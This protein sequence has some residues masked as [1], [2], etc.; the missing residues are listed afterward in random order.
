MDRVRIPGSA[1]IRSTLAALRCT[2]RINELTVIAGDILWILDTRLGRSVTPGR[3]TGHGS[4]EPQMRV[5]AVEFLAKGQM[6]PARL[7]RYRAASR[8]GVIS[9]DLKHRPPLESATV[10]ISSR[11]SSAPE[12]KRS[13]CALTPWNSSP[14]DT[15]PARSGHVTPG[16]E[17]ERSQTPAFHSN[18]QRCGS[19][20]GQSRRRRQSAPD[21]R[22]HHG[23]PRGWSHAPARWR[24][25]RTTS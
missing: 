11:S 22:L 4:K 12:A 16:R 1:P 15:C 20:P 2:F 7:R 13:R 25:N 8:L 17:T 10:G 9:E 6:P 21:A 3:E 24:R 5:N 18:R 19:A 14:L 23:I